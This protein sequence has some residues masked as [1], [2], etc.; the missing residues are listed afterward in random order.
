MTNTM[1]EAIARFVLCR[2]AVSKSK[3]LCMTDEV[4]RSVKKKQIMEE[5]ERAHLVMLN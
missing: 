3:P 1:Q 4:L 2:S 5:M